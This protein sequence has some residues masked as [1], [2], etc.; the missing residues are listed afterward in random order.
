M[1]RILVV[2]DISDIGVTV[3]AML[4]GSGHDVMSESD[5]DRIRSALSKK[6]F[7][8]IISDIFMPEFNGLELILKVREVSPATKVL[9]MTGGSPSFQ[10][11]TDALR[12]ITDSAEIFGAVGVLHKPFRKKDLID[13]V[14][15][16]V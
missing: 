4:A 14:N 9:V 12:D 3:E 8:L 6:I 11:G 13:A 5:P 2:D 15:E 10:R 1:A 7:D 16:L